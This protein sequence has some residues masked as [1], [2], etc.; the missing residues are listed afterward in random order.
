MS[1]GGSSYSD[2]KGGGRLGAFDRH[3][4]RIERKGNI[5]RIRHYSCLDAVAFFAHP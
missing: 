5:K 2:T 4:R 3:S 1:V